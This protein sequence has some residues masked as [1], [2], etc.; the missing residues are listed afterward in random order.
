VNLTMPR[1]PAS[2][3]AY[4]AA[5]TPSYELAPPAYV[6]TLPTLS[7]VPQAQPIY[8]QQQQPTCYNNQGERGDGKQDGHNNNYQNNGT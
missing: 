6:P 8:V 2:V 7:Y 1:A 5:A 4:V 3:P